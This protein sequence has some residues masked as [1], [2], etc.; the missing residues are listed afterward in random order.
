[1][2]AVGQMTNSLSKVRNNNDT[3]LW[4][5][6][7]QTF[8]TYGVSGNTLTGLEQKW[9]YPNS[10]LGW[11]NRTTD[12]LKYDSSGRLISQT[13]YDYNNG[14]STWK[15]WA[16]AKY[17]YTY[18]V[19]GHLIH[20]LIQVD[21]SMALANSYQYFYTYGVNGKLVSKEIQFWAVWQG[22]W[23]GFTKEVY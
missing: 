2:N 23:T 19:T 1:Y 8:Y 20:E 15:S 10:T 22:G 21:S 11:N 14:T 6:D 13:I 18:D 4:V 3:S 5:N 17:T 12:S 7:F 16:S 9:N